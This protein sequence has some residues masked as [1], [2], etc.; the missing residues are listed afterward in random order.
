LG[1]EEVGKFNLIYGLNG[2]AGGSDHFKQVI[3]TYDSKQ[4]F[5]D[6]DEV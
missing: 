6:E 4:D 5:A 3:A 1:A 2:T